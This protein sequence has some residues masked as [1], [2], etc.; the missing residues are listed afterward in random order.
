MNEYEILYFDELGV[1]WVVE[2]NIISKIRSKSFQRGLFVEK[3]LTDL[4]I[5]KKLLD[6]PND[7][8]TK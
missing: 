3:T 4:L 8:N 6:L 2:K 5:K 7:G 1:G